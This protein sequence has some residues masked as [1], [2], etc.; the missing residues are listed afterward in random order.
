MSELIH[1]RLEKGLKGEIQNIVN[2][3]LYSTQSGFIKE[4]MRLRLKEVYKERAIKEL[5]KIQGNG[6][7]ITKKHKAQAVKEGFDSK[8]DIFKEL[9]LE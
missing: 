8:R 1:L 6:K 7:R 5:S 3:G 2:D 4:A 9:G